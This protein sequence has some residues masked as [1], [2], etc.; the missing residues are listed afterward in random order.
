MGLFD[1]FSKLGK[2][3][4]YELPEDLD[5]FFTE[6]GKEAYYKADTLELKVEYFYNYLDR[7]HF[8]LYPRLGSLY[9][10]KAKKNINLINK[11]LVQNLRKLAHIMA[12]S[13]DNSSLNF[14]GYP[15]MLDEKIN[16][17]LSLIRERDSVVSLR[18]QHA[19]SGETDEAVIIRLALKSLK[20]Y[21]KSLG[22]STNS[23]SH[24]TAIADGGAALDLYKIERCIIW[25]FYKKA[26]KSFYVYMSDSSKEFG[27]YVINLA[28]EYEKVMKKGGLDYDKSYLG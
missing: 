14:A 13:M 7:L 2:S 17:L 8:K 10:D 4:L 18:E 27:P 3:K 6:Q 24:L 25:A 28:K 19:H 20:K 11:P 1:F 21:Q 12:V 16:P 5:W 23:H 22:V 26:E 9:T 15:N